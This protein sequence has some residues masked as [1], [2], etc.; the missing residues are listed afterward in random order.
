MA[1]V[2]AKKDSGLPTHPH[3]ECMPIKTD[4]IFIELSDDTLTCFTYWMM[5]EERVNSSF[6]L[7]QIHNFRAHGTDFIF[8]N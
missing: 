4:E 1:C 5:I 3:F 8:W 2:I 7:S 6:S